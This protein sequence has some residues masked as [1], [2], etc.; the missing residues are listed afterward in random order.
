MTIPA[1]AETMTLEEIQRWYDESPQALEEAFNTNQPRF[2]RGHPKAGQWR[3]KIAPGR[4]GKSPGHLARDIAALKTNIADVQS[5]FGWVPPENAIEIGREVERLAGKYS[6]RSA[7]EKRLQEIRD[8]RTEINDRFWERLETAKGT[9]TPEEWAR[10]VDDTFTTPEEK[11]RLSEIVSEEY[12]L[13]RQ[14]DHAERDALLGVLREI[15]PMGGEFKLRTD[16][17][18]WVLDDI[19]TP[20]ASAKKVEEIARERAQAN[21]KE[22]SKLIPT[23]WIRATNARSTL[24]FILS[25][26]RGQHEVG[27][28]L[29]GDREQKVDAKLAEGWKFL[30]R[31]EK[32]HFPVMQDPKGYKWWINYGGG[33]IAIEDES[34][35]LEHFKPGKRKDARVHHSVIRTSPESKEVML[36]ELGHHVEALYGDLDPSIGHKPLNYSLLKFL[37]DRTRGEEAVKLQE[38]RPQGNYEE[39]E[40]ATPDEFPQPYMGRR[41]GVFTDSFG[42]HR[43]TELLSMGLEMLFYTRYGSEGL[44]KTPEVR[45]F[46][47]GIMAAA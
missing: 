25:D 47:V 30:G 9:M 2:P 21:L 4:G 35:I 38:L 10:T 17:D 1:G 42:G 11:D 5:M 45:E 36:H 8:E 37:W 14:R 29:H 20:G 16:P 18:P 3:P 33:V 31:I 13:I 12:D 46:I 41:Y 15:R 28:D 22:V 32:G 34:P 43:P 40:I 26:K 23:D 7:Y 6:T 44:N 19:A 24:T 39:H 27:G